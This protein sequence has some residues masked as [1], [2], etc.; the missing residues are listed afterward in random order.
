MVVAVTMDSRVVEFREVVHA[1]QDFCALIDHAAPRDPAWLGRLFRSLPR[2]HAAI[3]A[4]HP[5]EG[6][7]MLPVH[8]DIEQRFELFSRLREGLGELD[9]YWLE[10]DADY[11]ANPLHM[12]G[13]LADDL[14]DIYFDLKPGLTLLDKVRQERVLRYWQASFEMH[15]GQHLVDAE[16]HLYALKVQQRFD[17]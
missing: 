10:Y 17:A 2:L 16:R 1:A 14:T 5:A 15:W 9:S 12:S 8:I 11:A 7:A 13:S 3:C 6:Q 4:L